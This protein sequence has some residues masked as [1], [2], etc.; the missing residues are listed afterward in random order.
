MFHR[1]GSHFWC[2]LQHQKQQYKVPELWHLQSRNLSFISVAFATAHTRFD[3]LLSVASHSIRMLLAHTKSHFQPRK[4]QG[5]SRVCLGLSKVKM[6]EWKRKTLCKSKRRK[7]PKANKVTGFWQR[8]SALRF[9]ALLCICSLS[10]R[11][12][13][14]SVSPWKLA[15]NTNTLPPNWTQLGYKH[16]VSTSVGRCFSL[17][18]WDSMHGLQIKEQLSHYLRFCMYVRC[19]NRLKHLPPTG[20]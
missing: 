7:P 12:A 16:E 11:L 6:H 8:L 3:G 15:V 13:F 5:P 10:V 14:F 19:E 2:E 18:Q 20:C 4:D 9:S 1:A 17:C